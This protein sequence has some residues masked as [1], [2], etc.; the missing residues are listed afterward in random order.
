MTNN[1]LWDVDREL[2]ERM[3]T[4]YQSENER[5]FFERLRYKQERE[6]TITNDEIMHERDNEDRIYFVRYQYEE[7]V[8]GRA[9]VPHEE[10]TMNLAEALN[11]N[12][13]QLGY[14]DRDITLWE[15]FRLR[16]YVGVRY[17]RNFDYV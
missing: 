2:F 8:F 16:D 7:Y 15:W 10:H 17:D 14:L 11:S 5:E 1:E 3:K 12:L 6:F 9:G 13:M 4:E